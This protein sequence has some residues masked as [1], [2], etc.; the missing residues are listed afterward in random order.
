MTQ[1]KMANIQTMELER[2]F[3]KYLPTVLPGYCRHL[4]PN[5]KDWDVRQ[6]PQ[7]A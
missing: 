3:K 5:G 7:W 1:I 2:K 4:G 6:T